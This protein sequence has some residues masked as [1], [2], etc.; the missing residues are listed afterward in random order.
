MTKKQRPSC[1]ICGLVGVTSRSHV[2]FGVHRNRERSRPK[3]GCLHCGSRE[4]TTKTHSGTTER[5]ASI[6]K[7]TPLKLRRRGLDPEPLGIAQ[8]SW[9][10]NE[11]AYTTLSR[12]ARGQP[13]RSAVRLAKKLL[14]DMTEAPR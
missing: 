13:N 6:V 4:H 3:A 11:V 2:E 7:L 10:L 9:L 14:R 8:S 5:R 12:A 1:S